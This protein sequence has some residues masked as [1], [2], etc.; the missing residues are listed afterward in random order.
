MALLLTVEVQLLSKVLHWTNQQVII[1]YGG[2][3]RVVGALNLTILNEPLEV[4]SDLVGSSIWNVDWVTARHQYDQKE[5]QESRQNFARPTTIEAIH[6]PLTAA[7]A[8][9]ART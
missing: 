2:S 4:A 5:T 8:P 1:S 9:A 7:R 6:F 3:L